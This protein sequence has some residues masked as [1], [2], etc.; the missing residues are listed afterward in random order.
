MNPSTR[1]FSM[2]LLPPALVDY[3]KVAKK[4]VVGKFFSRRSTYEKYPV[5]STEWTTL[6]ASRMRN[7]IVK[8]ITDIQPWLYYDRLTAAQGAAVAQQ[9]LFF[10]TP[11]SAT[12][13]QLDTN[14][15]LPSQLPNPKHFLVTCLRFIFSNM[16]PYDIEQMTT[17]YYITFNIGDK[18]YGEGHF[19][20]YPGGAGVYAALTGTLAAGNV[21]SVASN[22]VPDPMSVNL[23]GRENGIHILQGQTFN[24]T[25]VAPNV[26]TMTA[27][28]AASAGYPQQGRG[29]NVR[30]V[31]DGI[32][33]RE[34]Q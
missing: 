27:S 24:V 29:L 17:G 33:Y 25:A 15:A 28:A 3:A 12:K 14:L 18:C 11:K 31:L 26:V 13:T 32:L 5:G 22:G 21:A 7:P 1:S 6:H 20:T 8:D 16:F 2:N 19:D 30:A 10:T 23:W 9:L 4:S 34:V